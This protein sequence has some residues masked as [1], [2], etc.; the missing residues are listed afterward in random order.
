MRDW[1]KL[2]STTVHQTGDSR[3]NRAI[4]HHL[5]ANCGHPVMTNRERGLTV[6]PDKTYHWIENYGSKPCPHCRCTKPEV[7]EWNVS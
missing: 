5:C 4:P 3:S 2:V 1:C 7:E 6:E